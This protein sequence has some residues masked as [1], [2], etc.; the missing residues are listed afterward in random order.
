MSEFKCWKC[1][2]EFEDTDNLNIDD[3]KK[4]N[5]ETCWICK[6]CLHNNF[7]EKYELITDRH[8]NEQTALIIDN[9]PYGFRLRTQIR[10]W[11]ETTKN[12]DRFVAQTLNPK[13]NLWNKEK[14][15]TYS[16][17]MVLIKEKQTSYISYKSWSVDYTYVDSLNRFLEFIGELPLNDNQKEKI[18]IGRAI[19]KTREH[20]TFSIKPRDNN[21]DELRDLIEEK[22]EQEDKKAINN[23][24]SHYYKQE[25]KN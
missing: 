20:I 24:F 6:D 12:G 19:Y 11:I 15:T 23:I 4:E 13:T 22:K 14:K 3:S 9:Y 8:D 1:N 17:V 10:Y 21:R 16:D 7:K 2:K 25:L 5:N 18:R